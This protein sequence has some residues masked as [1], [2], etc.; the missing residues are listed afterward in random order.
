MLRRLT[1]EPV[2]VLATQRIGSGAPDEP[3]GLARAGPSLLRISVGPLPEDP[4]ARMVRERIGAELSHPLMSKVHTAS[5]GNPLFAL[6]IARA[7]A[8]TGLRADA[9]D[10]LPV[11]D[12]LQQL[13]SARLASLPPAANHALLTVAASSQTTTDLVLGA[14]PSPGGRDRP[15]ARRIRGCDRTRRWTSIRFSHPLFGAPPLT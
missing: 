6:E 10:P 8:R 3:V 14:S 15:R 4:I 13:L 5:N 11:P 7:V 1:D 12:D 9:A 2:S